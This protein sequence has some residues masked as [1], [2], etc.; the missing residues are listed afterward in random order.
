[1]KKYVIAFFLFCFATAV[2]AT[3]PQDMKATYSNGVLDVKMRHV[4]SETREHY[5]RTI[6][7][8]VN[9]GEPKVFRYPFQK[10]A[11]EF[12]ASITIA[13]NPG[14]KVVVRAECKQGGSAEVELS[15]Y[16]DNDA[17]TGK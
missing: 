4:T 1:M 6:R 7:V 11:S 12:E 3:P 10:Y 14:D 13:L 5:I 17:A 9:D 8:T 16:A 15:I 2:Y